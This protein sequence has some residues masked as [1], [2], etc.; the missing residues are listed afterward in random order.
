[1]EKKLVYLA[2]VLFAILAVISYTLSD[3]NP[4]GLA[5][6][7]NSEKPLF[8]ITLMIPKEYKAVSD[9]GQILSYLEV[10]RMGSGGRMDVILEYEII[11]P[12]G[13]VLER[14]SET[15]AV[16]TENSFVRYLDIPNQ[17]GLG[18]YTLSVKLKYP[19]NI[20][21]SAEA[22]FLVY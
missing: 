22:T 21:A 14:K 4:T 18:F 16:E 2:L 12:G 15:V 11:S 17:A 7:D 5:S 6:R 19:E 9:G 3:R 1:M 10:K 13:E 8:Q 20:E